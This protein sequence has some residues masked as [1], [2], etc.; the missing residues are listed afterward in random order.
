MG[1]DRLPSVLL[2]LEGLAVLGASIALYADGGWSWLAYLLL[3]LAPDL[4][5]LGYLA[6]PRTGALAYNLAH[7]AA[8]PVV[9]GAAGVVTGSGLPVQ[10]ALIWLG[11]IG[12][13]HALGYGLKYPT[14]FGDTHLQ[15]V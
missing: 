2:R 11:H 15:R 4:A 7:F 3:I 14:A 10:L 6:G 5:M 8:L 13:D 12:M 9:L 1:L